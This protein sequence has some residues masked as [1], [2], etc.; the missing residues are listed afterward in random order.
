[1]DNYLIK[2]LQKRN[3]ELRIYQETDPLD[4]RRDYDNLGKMICFHKRYDLGDKTDLK[5]DNFAGWLWLKKYLIEE[6]NAKVILPLYL[7][8]HSGITISTNSFNCPWDSGQIG[9]IYMDKKTMKDNKLNNKKAEEILR[10]EV[11]VYDKYLT[12]QIYSFLLIKKVKCK[13][14]GHISEEV[15]DS[16]GNFLEFDDIF[17]E[18]GIN[19]DVKTWKEVEV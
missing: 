7:Y 2:K 16:C 1:M 5:S 8:D 14:C 3:K 17:K 4:P 15:I 11:S 12:G 19:N 10:N 13:C 18:A 6:K 9:F